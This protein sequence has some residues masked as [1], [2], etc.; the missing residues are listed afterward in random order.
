MDPPGLRRAYRTFPGR[1]EIAI[2][3]AHGA[4]RR[5]PERSRRSPPPLS[6]PE[7]AAPAR[8]GS[9]SLRAA[10]PV[11][12]RPASRDPEARRRAS[13]ARRGP[14]ERVKRTAHELGHPGRRHGLEVGV[15][16]SAR[17]LGRRSHS[18]RMARLERAAQALG[19][20]VETLHRMRST[21]GDEPGG[22]CQRGFEEQRRGSGMQR[23]RFRMQRRATRAHTRAEVVPCR[24]EL[25]VGAGRGLTQGR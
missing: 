23:R 12:E 24:S 9:T 14:G 5:V 19:A 4:S 21:K 17:L 13:M 25:K 1:G 18:R 8:P 16:R 7:N 11:V 3:R 2:P 10:L 15:G 20:I 22:Q 6:D